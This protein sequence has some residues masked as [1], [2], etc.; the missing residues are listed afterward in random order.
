M[1]RFFEALADGEILTKERCIK[2]LKIIGWLIL[3][4]MSLGIFFLVI[5]IMAVAKAANREGM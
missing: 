4:P 5:I 2:F 1:N 3:I